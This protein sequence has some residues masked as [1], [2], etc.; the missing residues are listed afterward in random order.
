MRK[1]VRNVDAPIRST[2]KQQAERIGLKDN[3]NTTITTTT[4]NKDNRDKDKDNNNNE[5]D[6]DLNGK[7][8]KR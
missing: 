2:V 8:I 4:N 5:S 3:A 7:Q 6:K 1:I